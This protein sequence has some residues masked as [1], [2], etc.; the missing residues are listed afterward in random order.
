MKTNT[1]S[2]EM[3]NLSMH[4]VSKYAH[5]LF[6]IKCETD[7]NDAFCHEMESILDDSGTIFTRVNRLT[8]NV[9]TEEYLRTIKRLDEKF[10]KP[11]SILASNNILSY[12]PENDYDLR[13]NEENIKIRRE[14]LENLILDFGN[15]LKKLT[16]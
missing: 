15:I 12:I 4:L 8:L 3:G 9:F 11:H 1:Y 2:N 6:E 5:I 14:E 16:I 10:N 13:K 7:I